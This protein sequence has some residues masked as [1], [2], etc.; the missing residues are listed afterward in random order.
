MNGYKSSKTI[1][2]IQRKVGVIFELAERFGHQLLQEVSQELERE[3]KDDQRENRIRK[4]CV[5]LIGRGHSHRD[6]AAHLSN[7]N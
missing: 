6:I 5:S 4:E 2:D 7:F 3:N 1:D